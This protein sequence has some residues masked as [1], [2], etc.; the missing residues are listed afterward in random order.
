MH[1]INKK[2]LITGA[3]SGIGLQLVEQLYQDNSLYVIARNQDKINKLTEKYPSI[4]VFKADL[5]NINEVRD[6]TSDIIFSVKTLDVLINNAALQN[7]PKFI[8]D[9]FSLADNID[10]ITVN[11]TALTSLTYLLLSRLNGQHNAV[12]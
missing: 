3:T 9:D 8:D 11:F 5:K 7:T 4:T 1:L 2:I 12:S 10:E 6:V